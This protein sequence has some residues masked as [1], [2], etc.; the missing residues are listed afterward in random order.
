MSRNDKSNEQSPPPSLAEH[1][2][3]QSAPPITIE[4][5]SSP[6][7]TPPTRGLEPS[8]TE[9][10]AERRDTLSEERARWP[11]RTA[12]Q[13]QRQRRPDSREGS[14][15]GDGGGPAGGRKDQHQHQQSKQ[16]PSPQVHQRQHHRRRGKRL[17]WKSKDTAGFRNGRVLLIDYVSRD[18][19]DTGRRKIAAQEFHH[20]E[21]LR[22]FYS[23]EEYSH[24]AA[25]RVIH[26]QN[27]TWATRFL[28]RKFNIDHRND[29]VGTAFG[30][31][32]QFEKPQNRAGKPVLNGKT[33]RTQRDPWRGIS[34]TSFGLDYLKEYD[35]RRHAAVPDEELQFKMM[36]LNH[37]DSNENAKYGYDVFVQRLSVYIQ[38]SEGEAYQPNDPAILN[39]YC[40]DDDEEELSRLKRQYG[41]G[42]DAKYI[43]QL[44][45]LDNGSVIIIFEHSQSGNVE[46]TLIGAREELE[47]K[48]RR[49]TFY[50]PRE[51][52]STDERLALECMDLILRDVFKGLTVA[53]E[54]YLSKCETHVSIL[55]DKI[56]ENPADESRAPELWRNSSL[57][58]KVEKLMFIHMDIVKEMKTHLKDLA[59]DDQEDWLSTT[60]EDFEKLENLVQEDLVKPTSNLSDLMYKSV[61]IRDSR[62]SLQLGMSMWRLSWITFIFLPLTFLVSFFGMNVDTFADMPSIKW[63]FITAVPFM[64]AVLIAWYFIKHMLASRRQDPLRRGVY[65]HLYH[66]LAEAHPALWSRSGPRDYVRPDGLASALKWRLVS[67][68]FAP[69][70]TIAARGYDPGADHLGVWARTKR[71]LARRW[72]PHI[73]VLPGS[74][75]AAAAADAMLLTHNTDLGE[76]GAAGVGAGARA[77]GAAS[78]LATAAVANG[79]VRGSTVSELVAVSMPVA[80]AE[81][82]PAAA[83][84]ASP[85]LSLTKSRGSSRAE[86]GAAHRRSASGSGDEP[87][88]SEEAENSE[89]EMSD[90]G[91]GGGGGGG[92]N[93]AGRVGS[94]GAASLWRS[95]SRGGGRSLSPRNVLERLNVPLVSGKSSGSE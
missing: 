65:E 82:E 36:E 14:G 61:E 5:M 15:G 85:E 42:E 74:A 20:L 45:T 38:R 76:T 37:Y 2:R 62:H 25:L 46:D 22:R 1:R 7:E 92:G 19:T 83:R 16:R 58:L 89:G 17:E 51:E 23:N 60:M 90:G 91:S 54:K 27:A 64:F 68:W 73:R 87:M 86:G 43:P 26:V 8:N 95:S 4:D 48:W 32:A 28:L 75:A 49:L 72:L 33:F 71:A 41:Y 94:A 84:A 80:V 44:D 56:Y 50:L 3:T 67:F 40:E 34:R 52:V 24:Q 30:R 9:P 70:R 93:G 18:H 81:G 88:I 79:G 78:A 29:L 57:W 21:G 66:E 31:W 77:R 55:E 63:Y 12:A 10:V 47:A 6:L 53:W 11:G 35:A 69:A 13:L 59:E 39:P